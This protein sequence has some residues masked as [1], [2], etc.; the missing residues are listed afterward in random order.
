MIVYDS[1]IKG[2]RD[3]VRS[4]QIE[5]KILKAFKEKTGRGT[6]LRVKARRCWLLMPTSPEFI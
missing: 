6:R 3:D 2:F 4:N 5:S 1:N